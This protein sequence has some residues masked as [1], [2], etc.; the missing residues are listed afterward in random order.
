MPTVSARAAV[1]G[2][3]DYVIVRCLH[4]TEPERR[5]RRIASRVLTRLGAGDQLDDVELAVCELVTNARTHAPPPYELRIF[6][7]ATSVMFAVADGGTDH[8]SLADRWPQAADAGTPSLQESGR[9]LLVIAALFPGA[10]GVGPAHSWPGRQAGKQV[11][12]S[13]H[14]PANSESLPASWLTL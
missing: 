4:G 5:A 10:C 7:D 3:H 6:I 2:G 13:A 11:W 1:H 9:G 12:I 14:R 8:E